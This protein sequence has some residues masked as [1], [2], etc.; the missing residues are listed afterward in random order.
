M[1]RLS[2]MAVDDEPLALRRIELLLPQVPDVELVGAA[3]SGEDALPLIAQLKPDVV[4]LDVRMGGINGFDVIAALDDEAPQIIFITAFDAYAARAFSVSATDYLVKPVELPRLRSALVKARVRRDALDHA[5][6]LAD[7]R[8]KLELLERERTAPVPEQEFWVERR[9]EFVRL[10]AEQVDWVQA[11]RD[12]VYLHAQGTP[13]LVR[14]TMTAMEQKLGTQAFL[15]IHR[16]ALVRREH[17][18]VIRNAGYG[19]MFVRLASGEELRVGRTY[20]RKLRALLA[21]PT[22]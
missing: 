14:N 7:L 8:A 11:E 17:I 6:R 16:S 9:G 12:S 19:Q 13:F 2:I 22:R 1:S 15:R 10:I 18:A 4:L 5:T 20:Q 3:S 21:E